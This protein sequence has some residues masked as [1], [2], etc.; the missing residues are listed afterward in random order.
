MSPVE[1]Q[2]NT[3]K[4]RSDKDIQEAIAEVEKAI[5]KA[6]TSNV[7]LFMQLPTI[8]QSLNELL[9]LREKIRETLRK[10]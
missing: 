3:G 9:A 10:R 2:D 5:V 6:N 1:F 4:P 7:P 8:R